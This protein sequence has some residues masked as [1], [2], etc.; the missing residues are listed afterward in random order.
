MK[1]ELKDKG[2]KLKD[3]I[4]TRESTAQD[5]VCGVR[6]DPHGFEKRILRMTHRFVSFSLDGR[7]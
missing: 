1:K 5:D 7:R 4:L 6:W 3:E 2:K